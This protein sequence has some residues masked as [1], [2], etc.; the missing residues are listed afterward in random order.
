[1]KTVKQAAILIGGKGT[2][3]GD[4][5]RDTPKP[6]LEVAGRPFVEH[7]LLNLRRFGFNDFL[8][9]AGYQADVVKDYYSPASDFVK[10]LSAQLRVL[11][12]PQPMGTGGA[13]KYAAPDLQEEFLLLNGDSI[14]DF[15]YLDLCN[16]C[17]TG[18]TD[19]WLGK[20]A[21]LP[22]ENATRYG[23]VDLK[24]SHITA[25]REKP[26]RP[27]SGL[28]NSGVYWLRKSLLDTLPDA[29]CSLEQDVFPQLVAAG[30]LLGRRYEGFF[31]DIGIPEDL[32]AARKSLGA[33]LQKPAAFLDRDGTLNHDAGY[34]HKI[35]EFRW[36]DG[37][38]EAIKLLN[39]AGYLVFIV[40]NQAGIARGKYDTAAVEALH[41]WIQSDLH[42]IGAHYDDLRF[43]PHH[44]EGTVPEL[45]RVCA[46]RKPA[47][48]MLDSL[49][50]QWQPDLSRSFMLGDAEKDAQ[51]GAAAGMV[52]KQIAPGDILLAVRAMLDGTASSG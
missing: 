35:D 19:D 32:E 7:V 8:L 23:F 18:G 6:L 12:E 34:T 38:K 39:D 10:T 3:L 9:L 50:A 20:V 11:V 41:A 22:V 48:G 14:F 42:E 5:V 26:D 16:N 47:T 4:A 15:N 29:P 36:I 28:I 27:E 46:C 43:C 2:R 1:M 25:F 40:T 44:P 17:G 37:A 52:G 21:L 31:I 33:N 45:R 24:R 49:I 30:Q 51:A 13:L